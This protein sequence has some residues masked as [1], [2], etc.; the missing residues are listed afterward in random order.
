MLTPL[1]VD[2]FVLPKKGTSW[3]DMFCE[4]PKQEET[5]G[6]Q[7][8]NYFWEKNRYAVKKRHEP[9]RLNICLVLRRLCWRGSLIC[10]ATVKAF[11]G[12]LSVFCCNS[13]IS[14]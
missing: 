11:C 1:R 2:I 6:E 9:T 7:S 3:S 14:T 10:L 5:Q 8:A 13:I 4:H 12:Y